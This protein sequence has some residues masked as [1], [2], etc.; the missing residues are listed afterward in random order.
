MAVSFDKVPF[1]QC[2]IIYFNVEKICI[3]CEWAIKVYCLVSLICSLKVTFKTTTSITSK[4]NNA[5]D[6]VL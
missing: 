6:I 1:T 5:R 3:L 4:V 2:F